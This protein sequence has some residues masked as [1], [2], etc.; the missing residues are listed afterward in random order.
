MTTFVTFNYNGIAAG[1]CPAPS[2]GSSSCT[3]AIA[4]IT[5][6]LQ[7]VKYILDP[8]EVLSKG[9]AVWICSHGAARANYTAVVACK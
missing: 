1:A 3:S 6:D 9:N 2:G 4:N 8:K 7:T 5:T